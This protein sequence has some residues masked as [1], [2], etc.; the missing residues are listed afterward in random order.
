MWSSAVTSPYGSS[1]TTDDEI[2]A[3]VDSFNSMLTEVGERSRALEASNQALQHETRERR[4]AEDA[5]RRLNNTLEERIVSRTAELE[6][7]HEQ[8]RQSQKMEA[9]GQLTG[10]IAHDFNNMLQAIS[11]SLQ[12]ILRKAE[13]NQTSAVVAHVD[14]ARKAVD[15]AAA[16]TNRL[17]AFARRQALQPRAVD[18]DHL[19]RGITE[20]I[21]GTVGPAIALELRLGDGT[22]QVVCDPNQLEN[23]LLNVAIN[24]RD[25]MPAGG[26]LIIQTADRSLSESD[27]A[28]I[29]Y[30]RAG[31]YVEI[32][33]TDTGTGMDEATRARVFEPFFTTKPI[34]RGTGLGLSQVYGFVRQ[35]GGI[36]QIE[37]A[38]SVGTTVRL[39]L[40]RQESDSRDGA[41]SQAAA[42]VASVHGRGVVLLVEDEIDARDVMAEWLDEQ[43]YDV[44]VAGDGP[45]ALRRLEEMAH[46]D[47]LITDVG[48]PNGLNGRQVGEAARQR[49]KNLPILFITGY[50]GTAL[51]EDL[52]ANMQVLPKP[53]ALETLSEVVGSVL[54]DGTSTA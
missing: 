4:D 48:L 36:V 16:L 6:H 20:L 38:P 54:K 7:A 35:S 45:T 52:D 14:N 28:S 12:L 24:A 37:S 11:G 30:G 34:G 50:A 51:E 42:D 29:D 53:F 3:L 25:A 26:R 15:R 40:P 8:L 22:W 46:L 21:R 23:A 39:Q 33:V 5:V 43:G 44:V 10:G 13:R 49:W 18:A 27:V 47:L 31:D 19:I 1:K 32:A 41:A 17:L 2:G 9:I